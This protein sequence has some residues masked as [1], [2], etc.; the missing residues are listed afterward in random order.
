MFLLAASL[1]AALLDGHSEQPVSRS[2][3]VSVSGAGL[4]WFRK[5]TYQP[6]TGQQISYFTA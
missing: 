4:F 6:S 1:A 5:L 3:S 2:P